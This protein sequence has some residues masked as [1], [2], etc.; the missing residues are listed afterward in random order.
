MS[1]E[2][3]TPPGSCGSCVVCCEALKINSPEITKKSGVLCQHC[4]GGGC[5]IYETRPQ[6]CRSFYCGWRM[7]KGF[8]EDWRPDRSGILIQVVPDHPDQYTGAAT[9]FNF[10]ILG[11]EAAIMRP[12][13]SEY[14]AQLVSHDVAVF[15]SADSP[16]TLINDFLKDLV[17]AGNMPGVTKMLLHIYNLHLEAKRTG[18]VDADGNMT[19]N[20][21]R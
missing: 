15:L 2:E 10:V 19:E 18:L 6:V 12:G 8:G 4:T 11:G 14:I 3:F 20:A 9:G 16:K 1:Q 7:I 5:G 13:V 21:L 17:A